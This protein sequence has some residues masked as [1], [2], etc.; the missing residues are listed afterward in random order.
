MGL[1]HR[2]AADDKEDSLDTAVDAT[3]REVLHGGPD[4][5]ARVKRIL[6]E[7][8]RL[9]GDREALAEYTARELA[10][11][12]AGAEGKAGMQAFLD[13]KDPPWAPKTK[14]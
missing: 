9:R 6:R 3:A 11:A 2:I 1:V 14:G 12:R 13:K 7:V 5:L 10:D 4:A 8:A